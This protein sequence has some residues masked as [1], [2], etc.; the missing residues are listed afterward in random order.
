LK[1]LQLGPRGAPTR[2][3][4]KQQAVRQLIHGSVRLLAAGEDPFATHLLIQ[5]TDKLL[6]DL[7]KHSA[8]R[9]LA[10]DWTALMKPEYKDALL[11]VHRETFNFLKHA[12]RDHDQTLHVGDIARSN[13][14][15]LGVCIY[16]FFALSNEL[17]D[18]MRLGIAIARLVF[19]DGFVNDDQRSLHDDAVS[20][21]GG[22]T[23]REF[24]AALR[25]NDVLKHF[26]NLAA[27][28]VE[29]LQDITPF[30]DEPFANGA[31]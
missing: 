21:F 1:K 31:G 26:P 11:E 8:S 25:T 5:S 28:R 24:V 3:L 2:W 18:H 19:P 4:T 16:N 9:K 12:D 27:E 20:G 23:L 17:T 7:V 10:Y 14:L 30:F 29:D 13:V 15:Q 6:I 22:F